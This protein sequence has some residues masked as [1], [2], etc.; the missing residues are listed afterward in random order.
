[1][2]STNTLL[3]LFVVG[4]AAIAFG[5]S[6][7]RML[8]I[9]RH[10]VSAA[11]ASARTGGSVLGRALELPFGEAKARAV[12]VVVWVSTSCKFCALS[13]PFY[14]RL[15]SIE[16][17][18]PESFHLVGLVSQGR[19]DGTG[20]FERNGVKLEV[21]SESGIANGL[22]LRG[23]PTLLLIDGEHKVI[24]VWPGFL[25]EGGQKAVLSGIHRLCPSC[26]G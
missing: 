3:N 19:A 26:P 21:L 10:A 11:P 5:L 25:D 24:G 14:R 9:A 20:Y 6:C 2:T 16:A 15:A 1:M 22:G 7:P 13:L 12:T 4:I 23:T 17:A 18:A 8:S